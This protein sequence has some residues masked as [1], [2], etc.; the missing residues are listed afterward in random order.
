MFL[1]R[2]SPHPYCH[3]SRN[4]YMLYHSSFWFFVHQ[5]EIGRFVNERQSHISNVY[6]HIKTT[7]EKSSKNV[8]NVRLHLE[9]QNHSLTAKYPG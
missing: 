2:N 6:A 4:Y 9:I 1:F 3:N 5:E 8:D 7:T